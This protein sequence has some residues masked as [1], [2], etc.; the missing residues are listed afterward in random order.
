MIEILL[1]NSRETLDETKLSGEMQNARKTKNVLQKRFGLFFAFL[2]IAQPFSSTLQAQFPQP[3]LYSI[4]PVGAQAGTEVSF[5]ITSSADLDDSDKLVF[6][7][8]GITS[9][10]KKHMVNGFSEPIANQ[11]LIK[12][13][14]DVPPGYYEVCAS[15]R[16][17]ISNSRIFLV[18][19]QKE[20]NEKEPN[21]SEEEANTTL[22]NSVVNGT[23]TGAGDVDQ[24]QFE[25]KKGQRVLITAYA[26]RIDSKLNATL[27]VWTEKGRRIGYSKDD[28]IKDPLIDLTLPEDGKY[29]VKLFDFIYR[30]GTDFPY[31]L[32]V[33]T[34]P[35]IDYVF[36]PAAIPGKKNLLTFYGRNLPGGVPAGI[37]FN[38]IS[39]QK[40]SL[41]VDVP[42]DSSIL[43]V[44]NNLPAAGTFLDAFYHSLKSPSGT[45]NPVLIQFATQNPIA[46]VEPNQGLKQSQKIAVPVDLYGQFQSKSDI[47][48]FIF[49]AKA[50]E[51][52]EIEVISHRAG[53]IADPQFAINQLI[54]DANGNFGQKRLVTGDDDKTNIAPGIYESQNDDSIYRFT[55]PA[56]GSYQLLLRDRYYEIRGDPRLVYRVV[57]RRPKPD[58]RLVT[59]PHFPVQGAN[60]ALAGSNLLIRK[61]GTVSVKVMVQRRDGFKQNIELSAEGLPEGIVCHGAVL[62]GATKQVE[63]VFSATEKIA[64]WEGQIKIVGQAKIE[65]KQ[66]VQAVNKINLELVKAKQK[67]STTEKSLP[68]L[69]KNVKTANAAITKSVNDSKLKPEDKKLQTAL[70]ASIKNA[71]T[72][73][74]KLK[75]A[76]AQLAN[77]KQAIVQKTEAVE[78]AKKEQLAAIQT[79]KRVSRVG[80]VVWAPDA[81]LPVINRLAQG[82]WLSVVKEKLPFA[83]NLKTTDIEVYQ[84]RQILIPV[85]LTKRDKFDNELSFTVAGNPDPKKIVIANPKIA[86][87]K[88]N[89]LFKLFVNSNA[90]VGSYTLS[91]N[92]QGAVSYQRNPEK[93]VREKAKLDKTIAKVAG[94]QKN[95]TSSKAE[96]GT[97]QKIV[98][99]SKVAL[100]GMAKQK[101]DLEKETA[102]IKSQM[103]KYQTQL[104]SLEKVNSQ[105]VSGLKQIQ[106]S[107]PQVKQISSQDKELNTV[108]NELDLIQKKIN[109]IN[110]K[111]SLKKETITK[112]LQSLDSGQ[113][114][115]V[116][117]ISEF[118]KT[119]VKM[120]TDYD[121]AV[122]GKNKL[123]AD[124]KK[125]EADLK[126]VQ[127]Q[128]TEIDKTYKKAVA[129]AKPKKLTAFIPSVPI[130]LTIKKA[131]VQ[132]TAVVPAG[133]KLKKGAT[134]DIKV[135]IKRQPDFKSE[136]KIKAENPSSFKGI[137]A[138]EVVIPEGK[139]EGVIKVTASADAGEGVVANYIFRAN[140][141][142][143]G[144]AMVDVPVAIT[145]VK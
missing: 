39:L 66:K 105:L 87:G 29:Y 110:S 47:D 67:L 49:E 76:Q 38:G 43:D 8:P 68:G 63:L 54:K 51:V 90:P 34:A 93:A 123:D 122:S 40:L 108:F 35:H 130:R 28:Y 22:I 127:T 128:K 134:M 55:V 15:G 37:E 4:F 101:S 56:D 136:V 113:K 73:E 62:Y 92:S 140:M 100:D 7:H 19:D 2:L 61:G 115:K 104:A 17:G 58:F 1:M 85:E 116:V 25:G 114:E 18:S 42:A 20:T 5:S 81:V 131:P 89:Q 16:F 6:S 91:W 75:T 60:K 112:N 111:V 48:S 3:R 52:F 86:K 144:K 109:E 97:K 80:T 120:K 126:T 64:D 98:E 132:L 50:K 125:M 94:L 23:I 44:K 82:L 14:P 24:F 95:V 103:E 53:G 12:V 57:I 124:L 141:N 78:K 129:Q 96:Q 11:F 59:V 138:A 135:K 117:K 88:A 71:A 79:L 36:P 72:E 21:Q 137:S 106:A 118:A 84:G 83:L 26:N 70:I 46:E 13:K 107:I 99:S 33:T 143:N 10:A 41:E 139:S 77:E 27:E 74:A 121:N 31:R 65:D 145:V 45:S 32:S 9:V 102:T 142:Y 133:G 30:G 119:L 69:Q